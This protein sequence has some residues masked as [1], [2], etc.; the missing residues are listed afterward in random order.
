MLPAES[1]RLSAAEFVEW[2][3]GKVAGPVPTDTRITLDCWR[4]GESM[5]DALMRI[6]QELTDGAK[7]VVFF[8]ERDQAVCVYAIETAPTL[9]RMGDELTVPDVL[10]GFAVPVRKFFERD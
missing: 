4:K 7:R 5:A 10:P 1:L 8:S 9:F 6:G 2:A 3:G